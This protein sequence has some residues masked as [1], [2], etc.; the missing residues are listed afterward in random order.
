MGKNKNPITGK[1]SI[2][3]FSSNLD[4]EGDIEVLL[5]S[6]NLLLQEKKKLASVWFKYMLELVLFQLLYL[7]FFTFS[8][9]KNNNKYCD[10]D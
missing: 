7:Y 10:R 3:D 8:K 4:S 1:F 5:H 6:L 9:Q 2:S